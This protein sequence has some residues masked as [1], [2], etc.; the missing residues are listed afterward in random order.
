M[1]SS[2]IPVLVDA[3]RNILAS[4]VSVVTYQL[5]TLGLAVLFY[6]LIII[7]RR[8]ITLCS[9]TISPATTDGPNNVPRSPKLYKRATDRDWRALI[10]RISRKRTKSETTL[11]NVD[12]GAAVARL[13]GI[14]DESINL[15]GCDYTS[16]TQAATVGGQLDAKKDIIRAGV[17]LEATGRRCLDHAR[18]YDTALS[19]AVAHNQPELVEK[20]LEDM[21]FLVLQHQSTKGRQGKELIWEKD[22]EFAVETKHVKLAS[23]ALQRGADANMTI[24]KYGTLLKMAAFSGD[25]AMV[26]QLLQHGADINKLDS[27]YE[28]GG[29]CALI[30]A[31]QAG[32]ASTVRLL[33]RRGAVTSSAGGFRGNLLQTAAHFGRVGVV[34]VI[35]DQCPDLDVNDIAHST[36]TLTSLSMAWNYRSG[37][38]SGRLEHKEGADYDGVLRLLSAR[39]AKF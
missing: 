28:I 26:R 21:V 25:K 13:N 30:A 38:A 1:T 19:P 3:A 32:S 7:Y 29:N 34:R 27:D 39:G 18:I 9:D 16:Q 8:R 17:E 5:N 12:T 14:E 6:E 23:W 2:I 4:L 20:L 31:A 11:V 22:L 35:L 33:L 15:T 10:K 24:P 37:V 36:S